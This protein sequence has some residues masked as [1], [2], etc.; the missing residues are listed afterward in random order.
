MKRQVILAAAI[1]GA[2]S[3]PAVAQQKPDAKGAVVTASEPGKGAI[4]ATVAVSARVEAIDQKTREVTLKGPEGKLVTVTVSPEVRNLDKVKVGDMVT[5]RYIEALTLTLKKGGTELRGSTEREG[6]ARAKPG[7]TPAGVVARQ[8]Q[9]TAD[10]I[11][12]DA[13]VPSIT[14]RGPN[15]T[16]ELK[17][18]PEQFKLVK[19][20]DQVEVVYTE[21]VAVALEPA[22]APAKK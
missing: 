5:M 4:V 10:V 8:V 3:L 20:G 11:A 9:V 2:V 6:A 16:V 7:E 12:V 17:V 14:L 13:K 18:K 1:I 15:R 22:A 19:V 21:A